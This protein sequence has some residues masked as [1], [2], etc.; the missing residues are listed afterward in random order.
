MNTTETWY[1]RIKASRGCSDVTASKYSRNLARMSKHFNKTHEEFERLLKTNID[2]VLFCI[3]AESQNY[4]QTVDTPPPGFPIKLFLKKNG[5]IPSFGS[6]KVSFSAILTLLHPSSTRNLLNKPAPGLEEQYEKTK[7]RLTILR[8]QEDVWKKANPISLKE[9][10]KMAGITL[11]D[12]KNCFL[13]HKKSLKKLGLNH[14][15]TVLYNPAAS[16]RL[17]KKLMCSA[18]YTCYNSDCGPPRNSYRN[19]IIITQEKFKQL[20]QDLLEDMNYLVI[21]SR[22]HK[23]IY[24]DDF[25]NNNGYNSFGNRTISINS[26]LNSTINL[27]LKLYKPKVYLLENRDG[28]EL[29]TASMTK[30][31]NSSFAGLGKKISS[32][33]IRKLEH[34]ENTTCQ[35]KDFEESKIIEDKCKTM[36]HSTTTAA[37]YYMGKKQEEI[38]KIVYKK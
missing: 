13:E 1:E 6:R 33:F 37:K 25:K 26:E 16:R 31:L 35:L 10:T 2:E 34:S 30:L 38:V 11:K 12:L 7:S 32:T 28:T 23:F 21:R 20:P 18:L 36:G 19:L 9:K 24:L 8:I 3:N 15:N 27:Y 14:K 22:N 17:L 29:S 5:Q 4:Q